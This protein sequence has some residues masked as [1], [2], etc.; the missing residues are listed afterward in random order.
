MQ[1]CKGITAALGVL[2]VLS[3]P[4]LTFGQEGNNLT[5]HAVNVG[6]ANDTVINFTNTGSS[7]KT[8]FPIP[9]GSVISDNGNVCVNI[10]ALTAGGG[11]DWCCQIGRAHV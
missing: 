6:A 10:Y 3:V 8:I 11:V 4:A 2:L 7:W 5:A 1:L 9:G